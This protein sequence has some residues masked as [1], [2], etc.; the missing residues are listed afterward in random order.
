M[1]E[2]IANAA[3][4]G[5]C[6]KCLVQLA[7]LLGPANVHIEDHKWKRVEESIVQQRWRGKDMVDRVDGAAGL[8]EAN[9]GLGEQTTSN[10]LE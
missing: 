5:Q 4:A 9:K 3:L 7:E 6:G 2:H 1:P 10:K 8:A